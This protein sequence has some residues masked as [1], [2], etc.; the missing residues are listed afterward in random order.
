MTDNKPSE[1]KPCP[2]PWC[3]RPDNLRVSVNCNRWRVWCPCNLCGPEAA[4]HAEAI[5]AWNT[6]ATLTDHQ[7]APVEY[8]PCG[9]FSGEE[10]SRTPACFPTATPQTKQP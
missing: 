1:L 5:I 4:S 2:N 6:R 3:D 8:C 7:P 10:H 9:A